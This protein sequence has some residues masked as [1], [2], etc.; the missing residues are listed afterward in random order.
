MEKKKDHLIKKSTLERETADEMINNDSRGEHG[1]KKVKWYLGRSSPS[2]CSVMYMEAVHGCLEHVG[3]LFFFFFFYLHFICIM[4]NN[5]WWFGWAFVVTMYSL[6]HYF[7]YCIDKWKSRLNQG[8]KWTWQT[9]QKWKLRTPLDCSY[10]Q[11]SQCTASKPTHFLIIQCIK[12]K[13]GCST[14]HYKS[15]HPLILG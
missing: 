9:K 13:L 2:T 11:P 5:Q 1:E 14:I 4:H 7:I 10:N 6:L 3:D 12:R 8:H 15:S